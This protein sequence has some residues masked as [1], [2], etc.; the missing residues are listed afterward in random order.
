MKHRLNFGSQFKSI[1]RTS[2]NIQ[3]EGFWK[4]SEQLFV[5]DYFWKKL[6]LRCLAR[7]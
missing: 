6:H 7:F 5:F 2:P 1:F 4:N 3:D